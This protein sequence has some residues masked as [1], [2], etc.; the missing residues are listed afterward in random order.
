MSK[1]EAITGQRLLRKQI[2]GTSVT[3]DA[4]DPQVWVIG[5]LPG[6]GWE[7]INDTT[8]SGH[9]MAVYRTYFDIKGLTEAEDLT[10]FVRGVQFQE[11]GPHQAGPFNGYGALNTFRMVTKHLVD[12]E[13]FTDSNTESAWTNG[14]WQAPGT[15]HSIRG[16]EDVFY[17]ESRTFLTDSNSTGGGTPFVGYQYVWPR[18]TGMWGTGS[19]TAGPRI[20]V[21]LAYYLGGGNFPSGTGAAPRINIPP[22]A[23]V[24]DCVMAKESD[25]VHLERARRSMVRHRGG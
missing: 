9:A 21:T 24:L 8:G 15:R 22:G 19:G 11:V 23:V 17:G 18:P 7:I 13:D 25:L 2:P 10:V 12:D 20:H 16:L 14:Y 1:E 3:G 4:E 6:E 5:N